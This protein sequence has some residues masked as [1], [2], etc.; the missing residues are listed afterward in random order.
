MPDLSLAAL[1]AIAAYLPI[2]EAPDFQFTDGQ[3]PMVEVTPGQF[4]MR[5]YTYN[6]QVWRLIDTAH[7]HGWVYNDDTFQWMNWMQTQEAQTLRDDPAAL[8][9]ATPL[10]LARL[11]TIMARQ[12]R[13]C[14]GGMLDW[15]KDGMLLG[16]LR[17]AEAL[18]HQGD[19]L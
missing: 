17:R 9:T 3:E 5:G 16:I 4:E 6:E 11:M 2:M 10:Q 18:T 1:K 19:L 12:E 15:W 8:T 7:E 14:E 13:F